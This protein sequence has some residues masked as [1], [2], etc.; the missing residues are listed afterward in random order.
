MSRPSRIIRRERA[1]LRAERGG[2]VGELLFH[3]RRCLYVAAITRDGETRGPAVLA[4]DLNTIVNDAAPTICIDGRESCSI[5]PA[6][7]PAGEP[8]GTQIR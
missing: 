4:I 1:N 3:Q 2:W 5:P 7:V 6:L 8:R